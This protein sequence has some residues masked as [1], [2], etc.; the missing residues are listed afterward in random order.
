[1]E[2]SPFIKNDQEGLASCLYSIKTG[3]MSCISKK[4]DKTVF[5]G[6]FSSGNNST[7]G[8]KNNAD[9]ENIENVGPI[10]TGLWVWGG[11]ASRSDRTNLSPLPGT[12]TFHRGGGSG[13]FQTHIC[14]NPF[15]P[16]PSQIRACSHG[17]I[18]GDRKTVDALNNLIRNERNSVLLVMP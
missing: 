5:V 13:P 10:P 11:Q 18:A 7:P 16:S 12:I 17:C 6:K 14:A 2:A 15:G 9:C 4:S 3:E 1:M 8:C